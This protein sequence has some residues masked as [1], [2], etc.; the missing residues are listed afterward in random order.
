VK[1]GTSD[2]YRVKL[3]PLS[4]SGTAFTWFA[5]LAPNS[6][7]TWAQPEQE[8][9]EYFYSRETELRLSHLTSVKQRHNEPICCDYIRMFRDVKN[10]CFSLNVV[11]ERC[12]TPT[13]KRTTQVENTKGRKQILNSVILKSCWRYI[14]VSN[15]IWTCKRTSPPS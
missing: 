14:C 7:V 11:L 3:F 13:M 5:S 1:V 15:F 2:V 12:L 4:L 6:I 8:S 9:H 10:R